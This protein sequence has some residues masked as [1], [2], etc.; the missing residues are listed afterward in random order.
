MNLLHGMTLIYLLPGETDSIG[1][2]LES[3]LLKWTN[4]P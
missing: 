3:K 1:D 4:H 2:T